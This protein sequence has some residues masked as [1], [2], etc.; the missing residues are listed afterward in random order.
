MISYAQRQ[1]KA[2]LNKKPIKNLTKKILTNHYKR[3]LL[4]NHAKI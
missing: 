1:V 2:K 4:A 3:G